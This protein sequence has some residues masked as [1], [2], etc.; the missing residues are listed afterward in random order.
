MRV[1]SEE[2]QALTGGMRGSMILY[3]L[4]NAPDEQGVLLPPPKLGHSYR[5][6]TY[7]SSGDSTFSSDSKYPVA[8]SR[9]LVPYAYDPT[10]DHNQADDDEDALHDMRTP[11][12]KVSIFT[13]RGM[14]NI[15]T[16]LFLVGGLM[17]LFVVYPVLTYFRDRFRGIDSRT[18]NIHINGTG[19]QPLLISMP[20]LIDPDTPKD[21]HARTGNDGKDYVLVFS[22][23]FE[24]PG[25]SFYPGDDPYW[26][27]V[28]LWYWATNDLEYYDPAQI[29][30]R[31]GKL[32]IT[33]ENRTNHE[34]MQYISGMLQS[35]NKFCFTSGYIEVAASFPGP[36]ED[37]TGYWPGV[38]TMGNL[39]RPGHG[40]TTDGLWPYSYDSCDVGTFP[41]QTYADKSGPA[42]ALY[43]EASRSKYNYE[44]SWLPGQRLSACTC[45]GED[46]PG[47][48]T[49][50]GRGAPEIDVLE[51]EADKHG[52][53]GQV[54]SQSAQ[55]APFTHDYLFQNDTADK[56]FIYDES[57]T[58]PNTYRGSAVQ[59][60]VSSLT[61]VPADMFQGSGQ[62]MKVFGFEYWADPKSRDDGF[63]TWYSDGKPS[64]RM[65]AAAMGPDSG[66]NSTGVSSRIIPEEPMSIVLNLGISRNWQKILP[67]TMMMP[68]EMLIDYV[69]VYQRKGSENIGCDPK[70]YPTQD[71]INR[72]LDAYMNPNLTTWTKQGAIGGPAGYSWPKNSQLDTC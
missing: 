53:G 4:A 11:D 55:F 40:A 26:E 71:Y 68:A 17:A 7:S 63:I 56:F 59:Q 67:E 48:T 13:S 52:R 5:D 1:A 65:G 30:T 42:S 24:N 54:I 6:S 70:D 9:G 47:P 10:F 35:W 28:D 27:A 16:L 15:G 29:T 41:N 19:Q 57:I 44:L 58:I 45:A 38:W 8:S 60:A 32:V 61:R 33:M 64:Y 66:V 18:G 36:N 3:R 22:D 31:N 49:S 72:H 69:R 12:K 43:S 25:R 34:G 39:G 51:A 2:T 14:L 20:Q 21:A 46:H 23:E 62:N 50:R 37:T